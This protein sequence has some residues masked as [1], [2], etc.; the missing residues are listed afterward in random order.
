MESL[1]RPPVARRTQ[2]QRS[3]LSDARMVDA[4]VALIATRGVAG[5]TL[6]EVGE[7]AGYSRALAGWRFGTKSNLCAAVVRTVGEEWLRA[8][9]QAVESKRGL[10]AIHA[11][12]DAHFSFVRDGADRIRVFYMLWFDSAG[13]DPELK[14]VI[15]NVHE[16]RQRDVEAWIAEG[17]AAGEVRHDAEVKAIAA[18]FCAAIIGI[19]YQWLVK[20][21]AHAEISA[22]H[23][24]LKQQMTR[25]LAPVDPIQ[26]VR[27]AHVR[28]QENAR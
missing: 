6:K 7:L 14:Q 22:L 21:Q 11:A 26:R 3:A 23:E 17:I 28:E 15:A 8:L 13:P 25:A 4:A 2:A 24:G 18:Q 1:V 19:V 12:T 9:R 20:P 10:A 5:T 27:T 16:R